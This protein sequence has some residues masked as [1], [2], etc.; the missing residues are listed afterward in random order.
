MSGKAQIEDRAVVVGLLEAQGASAGIDDVDVDVVV[1]EQLA[2][3]ELLGGVVFN[4]EEALAVRLEKSWMRVSAASRS[5]VVVGLVT[6]A[7]APRERPWWRS[8]SSVSICTGMWRVASP[9]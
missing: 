5:S 9:A 1:P 3:A 7:N 4:D 2:N 6:K 8:S